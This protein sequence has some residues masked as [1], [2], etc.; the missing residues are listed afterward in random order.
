MAE[1]FARRTGCDD[2]QE[3]QWW[4]V[5][6]QAAVGA[7][8]GAAQNISQWL[9]LAQTQRGV[10]LMDRLPRIFEMFA[11]GLLSDLVVR[12]IVVRT[13]LITDAAALTAVDAALAE[14]VLAWGPLS[15]K[16]T[17]AAIDALVVAHDPGAMRQGK[18]AELTR[19]FDVG[20]P[21][22]AAGFSSVF[23]R[24]LAADAAALNARIEAMARAVCPQDPR[25]FDER[26]ADAAG[27]LGAG[28]DRLACQCGGEELVKFSV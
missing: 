9:A 22:D 26:R 18:A 28:V 2:A 6:P 17:E 1:L 4:W 20:H 8:I 27:A 14:Q 10:A 3:R 25:T 12:A 5:D 11:A 15:A 19:S 23:G 24:L 13:E 16:K 7:E 21:R